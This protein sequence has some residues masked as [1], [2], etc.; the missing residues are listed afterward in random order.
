M[1]QKK[2]DNNSVLFSDFEQII[3][4]EMLN[5]NLHPLN[6]DDIELFW[7]NKLPEDNTGYIFDE[8]RSIYKS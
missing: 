6:K 7:E 1:C 8:C 2:F 3:A 5:Q 4:D